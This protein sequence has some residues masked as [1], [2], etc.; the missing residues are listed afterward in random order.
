NRALHSTITLTKT[1]I[2]TVSCS[3]ISLIFT[4]EEEY[5]DNWL[6]SRYG[7]QSQELML[8]TTLTR[9]HHLIMSFL[10]PLSF[11]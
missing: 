7:L 5:E 3:I 8:T 2:F 1:F 4:G 9:H 11:Y 10:M 6:V